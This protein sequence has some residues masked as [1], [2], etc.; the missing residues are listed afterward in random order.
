MKPSS[1]AKNISRAS[2]RNAT[3]LN[4]LGTPGLGS[5]VARRW[6]EGIGQLILSV[7]GF[8]LV[9]IWFIR[10][11]IPYY[12][13]MFNN[14]EPSPV[15][16]KMLALGAAMFALA[17]FWSLATSLSLSREAGRIDVASLKYF[18]A[19]QIKPDEAKIQQ[20]VAALVNWRRNG[21]II[22]RTFQFKD[23]PAAMQF[24]NAVAQV[25]E[26]VQHHP[27]IDIRWNKVTLALTT[28][29]AGGLTEK[30]FA[31]ARQC[32]AMAPG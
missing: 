25:A 14:A 7:I 11:I 13:E 19:G 8:A 22:S 16:L 21:E 18:A 12:G 24:V 1:P 29:D 5:L 10:E 4:L 15:G 32:D 31:M 28:H 3:L 17:W 30:D 2:A 27:D 6:L 20:A 9:L 26:Q 23:F